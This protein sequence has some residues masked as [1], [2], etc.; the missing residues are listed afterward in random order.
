MASLKYKVVIA[1]QDQQSNMA[2]LKYKVVIARQD[3][4]S[5]LKG[6]ERTGEKFPHKHCKKSLPIFLSPAGM[7]LIKTLPDRYY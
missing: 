6:L 3:Q 4:Q 7:S 1:R 5:N 2:S